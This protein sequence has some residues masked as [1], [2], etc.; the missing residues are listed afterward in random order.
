M[1][2]HVLLA[3]MAMLIVGSFTS[4]SKDKDPTPITKAEQ[5]GARNWRITAFTSKQGNNPIIDEFALYA[6]CDKDDFYQF[7]ADKTFVL[8]EGATRCNSNSPQTSVSGW[9]INADGTIL[10]LL[11][12]KGATSAELYDIKELSNDKLRIGQ[13]G[14]N[15]TTE[16]TFT[17]F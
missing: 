11:E 9:D 6:P 7:K 1:R 17:S 4:C 14:R 5:L 13:S 2:K 3:A 16:I 12:M 10:L 15:A 8:D